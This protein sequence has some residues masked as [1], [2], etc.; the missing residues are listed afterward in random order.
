MTYETLRNLPCFLRF[1]A[2]ARPVKMRRIAI[3]RV[4]E[5]SEEFELD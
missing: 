3:I 2:V 1:A 5:I 4:C